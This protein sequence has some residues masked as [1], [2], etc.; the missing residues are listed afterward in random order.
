MLL[1]KLKEEG[2]EAIG[3]IINEFSKLNDLLF[4]KEREAE[5]S[6]KVHDILGKS[7]ENFGDRPILKL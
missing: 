6:G 7:K 4:P 1:L 2:N 5:L 3:K